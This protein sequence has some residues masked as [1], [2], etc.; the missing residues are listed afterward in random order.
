LQIREVVNTGAGGGDSREQRL[1]RTLRV[2]VPIGFALV[3]FAA[4][5][6][7]SGY[8]YYTNRRDTLALSNDLLG[9]IEQRIAKELETFLAPIE[10]AVKLSEAVLQ[11]TSFDTDNRDLLEPLG[12]SVLAN[13]SQ[14]SMF[15]VADPAGNFFMVKKMSD[16]SLHTKIIDRTDEAARV[17]WI[18]RDLS[19]ET[20]AVE[21]TEDDSYDPRNRPW[22][23]GALQNRGVSW[24]DF[25]LFFT[26]QKLG[27]TVS[28]PI[29]GPGERLL[30][31]LGLDIELSRLNQFLQKLKIG[32]SGR[33]IIV[34][35]A[36]KVVGHP[37]LEEIIAKEGDEYRILRIE[38]MADPVLQRAY[39]RY[40]I[41]GHGK[42]ELSVD[43]RRYLTSA[44]VFPTSFGR[45]LT[46]FV[47]VPEEDFVGFLA[48][49]NR[50]VLLMSLGVLLLTSLM[51]AVM[52]IQGLRA[53]R[54]A[55]QVLAR[56]KELE[57][58]SRAFSELSSQA[59]LFDS[60]DPDA[61]GRLT[62]IVSASIG[63][64]R[65]S[66]WKFDAGAGVL[67]CLDSYDRESDDHTG[68]TVLT[69]ADMHRFFE[70]LGK[71]EDI[72]TSN[73]GE[74]D[75]LNQLYRAYLRPL[76]CA[77][78]LAVPIRYRQST[79]GWLWFEHDRRSR[80]WSAEEISFAHAIANML[81]LRFATGTT[82]SDLKDC[83]E[84]MDGA[85]GATP[86][87][88]ESS[89]TVMPDN[90][91]PSV[92]TAGA[93]RGRAEKPPPVPP[94]RPAPYAKRLLSRP[95]D[96]ETMAAEFF[97]DTT[98]C[99]LRLTNPEALAKRWMGTST[100]AYDYL[101]HQLEGMSDARGIEYLRVMGDEIVLAAGMSATSRDHCRLMAE[102]ALEVQSLCS[103]IF[104]RMKL[105]LGFRIGI[106][107]GAVLG[108]QLGKS[109]EIFNIWGDAMR[110][111]SMMAKTGIPGAIQVSEGTYRCVRS[112]YVFK[113]RGKFY[114]PGVGEIST[115]LLTG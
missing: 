40:Q 42:R 69:G 66:V 99:L 5:L 58:Q 12:F 46:V 22:Y 106:D 108:S 105:P 100:N 28:T 31:V 36:G 14:I 48:R 110:F 80:D 15:N 11:N 97:A 1:R 91:T 111:A 53:D 68:G 82:A 43:E 7:I 59:A 25:Y 39:S 4:L 81:A 10:D 27:I 51:A 103:G 65:T 49:N 113:A 89:A 20:L 21:E 16:G 84:V 41:E 70:A 37:E 92:G 44:F 18:R 109:R 101:V 75:R 85:E 47:F 30:G 63:V 95:T 104:E 98:V 96:P 19:G 79:S 83:L 71:S 61:L 8:A 24:T 78:L 114:L 73:A 94:G 13:I 86:P 54:S 90:R 60:A 87:A 102:T 72:H 23:T 112:G 34:N 74:D 32:R 50:N 38:E 56:Q 77:S 55:Q 35:D 3:I 6:A 52:V 29:I 2:I 88:K 115:Y 64:R 76:G 67:T 93:S 33:A 17:T 57:A 9:A 26:D 62:E 107:T 45:E